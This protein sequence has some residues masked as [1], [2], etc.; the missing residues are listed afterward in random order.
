MEMEEI[1]LCMNEDIFKGSLLDIGFN[2]LGVVYN[3]YKYFNKG[4]DVEYICGKEERENISNET[5]DSCALFFTISNMFTRS[6][7]GKLFKD[8]YEYLNPEGMVYIWDIDK[9]LNKIFN[10][11][12]RIT[13]PENEERQLK[14]RD[15]NIFKDS[16]KNSTKNIIEKYFDIIDEKQIDEVYFIKGKKKSEI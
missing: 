1:N 7:K 3:V 2:N 4:V 15:F 8:V 5:Y 14:L 11:N 10:K 6:S 16:S 12:I 9:G 13:M